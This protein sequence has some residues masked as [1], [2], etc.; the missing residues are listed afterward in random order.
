MRS[1]QRERERGAAAVEFALVMPILLLL[2][3]AIIDFGRLLNQQI[4]LTEAA[5]EGA[6][7]TSISNEIEGQARVDLVLDGISP[8]T[9]TI[10]PCPITPGPTDDAVVNIQHEFSFVT[11]VGIL[12]DLADTFEIHAKGVMP[13]LP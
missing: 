5:R 10:T 7:A 4:T 12:A 11:P 3:F 2:V 8:V 9:T 1:A 13:C 6:R